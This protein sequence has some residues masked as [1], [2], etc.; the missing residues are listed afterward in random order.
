MGLVRHA[1]YDVSPRRRAAWPLTPFTALGCLIVNCFFQVFVIQDEQAE[2]HAA[3]LEQ[4]LERARAAE[5]ARS[6]FFSIVSHDISCYKR[7]AMSTA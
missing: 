1:G 7:Y 6:L 4:A 3:E 2:K 5:K